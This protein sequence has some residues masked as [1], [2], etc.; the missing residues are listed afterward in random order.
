MVADAF[1]RT[2]VTN[3]RRVRTSV[4]YR[5][6]RC[7]DP[8]GGY[9]TECSLQLLTKRLGECMAWFGVERLDWNATQSLCA[10][11]AVKL[12]TKR[13]PRLPLDAQA[14]CILTLILAFTSVL[15]WAIIMA[16]LSISL[17]HGELVFS[18]VSRIIGTAGGALL[19]AALWYI[20]CGNS[21][22]GNP[23]GFGATTA[24]AFIPLVFFRLFAPM[25]LLVFGLMVFVTL[26]L[27]IGYS[28]I[29]SHL[30]VTV[31]SG[32]GIEVAWR[33]MLLVLVGIAVGVIIMVIPQPTSTRIAV[34]QSLAKLSQ[35]NLS[36][37]SSLVEI[38]AIQSASFE[39]EKPEEGG[40][41]RRSEE[42][43][44]VLISGYRSQL[45]TAYEAHK[46]IGAQIPLAHLDL[47]LRG[48]WPGTRYEQ[49]LKAEGNMIAALAQL[50][51]VISD[52]DYTATWQRRFAHATALLDPSTISDVSL[53]LS[54]LAQAL[55]TGSRLPH[56]TFLVRERALRHQS[57]AIRVEEQLR[58][59]GSHHATPRLSLEILKA[60][61]FMK[62]VQG[63]VAL[64]VFLVNLDEAAAVVRTLVG[65]VPL[66]GYDA[67]KDRWDDRALLLQT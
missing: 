40:M 29:D 6:C 8:V 60:E 7:L 17:T 21:P 31:S 51:A 67:L 13:S 43:E 20:S 48:R 66:N 25:Q 45:L 53:L 64:Q 61:A 65:E 19:G 52:K 42:Q 9:S 38:W 18:I 26:I 58:S 12:Y 56:A 59:M 41:A 49:L 50:Y 24:V 11:A 36:L 14:G 35:R 54:L 16:Q 33:R 44:K 27:T 32:I 3:S 34:R 39:G 30:A 15:Q 28:W 5:G 10:T 57:Q 23:Y 4:C 2:F 22:F 37:Y 62:H 46:A 63:A 1:P 55:Q 47:Q